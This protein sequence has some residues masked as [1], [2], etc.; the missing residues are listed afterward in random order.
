MARAR[1]GWVGLGTS[2]VPLVLRAG[3]LGLAATVFWWP[4]TTPGGVAAAAFAAV[5]LSVSADLFVSGPGARLRP[6]VVTLGT[7]ALAVAGASAAHGLQSTTWVAS[8][9]GPL[10]ALRASEVLRALVLTGAV[11]FLL[12]FLARRHPAAASLEI[13]V[14]GAGFVSALAAHREGMI[15]RPLPLGDF[16][17][18]HG[19]D[20]T[21]LLL[22]LGLGSALVLAALLLADQGGRRAALH[23]GTLALLV[24]SL[25]VWVRVAGLPTPEAPRQLGLTEDGDESRSDGGGSS[26]DLDFRNELGNDGALAPVAVV[27]LHDDYDPPEGAYYFRQSAF[28]RFNGRRLVQATRGDV[29]RDILQGFPGGAFAVPWTPPDE[30]DR[31]PLRTTTG[32]LVDHVKPFALDSPVM[33]EP[34]GAADPRFRR[35]YETLSLVQD[36]PLDH[37]LG[38]AGDASATW[39]FEQRRYYTELPDDPRYRELAREIAAN[40][41]P[42]FRDDP[43]AKALVVKFH[44][45]DAGTY[46]LKSQHADARDPVAS[47]LFGDLTGYCVHFAH[48][49]V[50]LLRALDVPARVGVGYAVP[51]EDRGG[52]SAILI[53]GLNS[54]AWP[55]IYVDGVGWVV[56]D[57]APSRVLDELAARP[58]PTLQ[59]MLGEMLREQAQA[60][61]Q[62]ADGEGLSWARIARG[63]A[64]LLAICLMAGFGVKL[65]RRAAPWIAPENELPRVAYRAAIDRL[66]G[67][68]LRRSFG[69]GRLGFAGRAARLAPSFARLS[70]AHVAAAWGSA[71]PRDPRECRDLLSEIRREL[72]GAAPWWQRALALLNPYD[73][74]L[75]R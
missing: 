28:S 10:G 56:V 54:H 29:D 40:L 60:E 46:S 13:A 66:A 72:R 11:V 19:L 44:L 26:R 65:Y 62:Q 38:V 55:E 34:A 23:L 35:V 15:H 48:A 61:G 68:G 57:I 16:A 49:A 17:W 33:V 41:K 32:L 25:V 70:D 5:A 6:A 27:V 51:A 36:A 75:A 3:V 2:T 31:A 71:R 50:Y 64:G 52:G 42:S 8:L 7:L 20:P 73:W 30:D 18:A 67:L 22:G 59:M 43:M 12:R 47:F 14:V 9:L 53:R 37:L 58:D 74:W 4:L 63:V 21:V 1:Q 24:L 45:D 39:S 69:E